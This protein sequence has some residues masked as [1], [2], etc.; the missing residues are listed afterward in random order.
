MLKHIEPRTTNYGGANNG[1]REGITIAGN[2]LVDI[3]KMIEKYPEKN[4]LVHITESVKAVGGCVQKMRS[5]VQ[6]WHV[7]SIWCLKGESRRLWML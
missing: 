5:T 4:M 1:Y 6:R 3:V 2:I 7:Y